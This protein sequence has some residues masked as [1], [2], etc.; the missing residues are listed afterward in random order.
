M[1]GDENVIGLGL[2]YSGS[3]D[4]DSYFGNELDRDSS[5]WI[6]ALEIVDELLEI[7][8][9]VDV[10]MRRRRNESNSRS[11]MSSFRNRFGYLVTTEENGVASKQV[12]KNAQR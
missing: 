10:V 8:N 11:R 1:T 3:D 7:L 4:S 6:G 2:G 9:R 12:S 5:T